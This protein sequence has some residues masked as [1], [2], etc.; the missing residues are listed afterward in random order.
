MMHLGLVWVFFV[1]QGGKVIAYESRHLKVHEKS[2]P[3]HDLE[4]DDVVFV[5]K[6]WRNNLY[7]VHVNMFICHK[8]LQY[9]FTQRELNLRQRRW[10]E[11]LK[12]YDMNFHNHP[13]I[14]YV[15]DDALSRMSMGSITHVED[16]KKELVK[17]YID[18]PDWVCG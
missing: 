14:T 8:S 3:I 9:V 2:Y 13:D 10:L 11:L 16:G 15:V 18:W 12:D 4:L 7:G 5:M 1:K 17:D 6:L